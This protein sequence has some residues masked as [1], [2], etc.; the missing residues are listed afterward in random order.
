M[1]ILLLGFVGWLLV[2][3]KPENPGGIVPPHT[4]AVI[5]EINQGTQ[6][7]N[8]HDALQNTSF[9]QNIQGV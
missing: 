3:K 4:P 6:F 2:R 1:E 7:E 9:T 8:A 5:D